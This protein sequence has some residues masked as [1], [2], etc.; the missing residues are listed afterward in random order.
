MQ[1]DLVPRIEYEDT[2]EKLARGRVNHEPT[3]L[4]SGYA[5]YVTRKLGAKGCISQDCLR[6]DQLRKCLKEDQSA[7]DMF[8]RVLWNEMEALAL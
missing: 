3:L 5:A 7:I 1:Q 6:M 4:S 8:N 2:L